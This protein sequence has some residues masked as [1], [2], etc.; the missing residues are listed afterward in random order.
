[1]PREWV[2]CTPI[3]AA[4][5]LIASLAGSLVHRDKGKRAKKPVGEHTLRQILWAATLL[6]KSLPLNTPM[7]RVN[8]ADMVALDRFFENL[9]INFGKAPKDRDLGVTLQLAI[10][11]AADEV[12][13]G[14]LEAGA[15]GLSIGTTNKH[16][17]KLAQIHKFMRVS[18][19]SA[20]AIDITKFTGTV[21]EN[22]NEAR[23]RLT[24]E[25]GEAIFRLP[26]WCGCVGTGDR[27]EPGPEIFHD[28][29]FYLLLLVWFTGAR[30]EELCKLMLNDIV[31][32]HDMPYLLI[33]PTETGGA[34]NRSVQAHDSGC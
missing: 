22:D 25:Q 30:R 27:L 11:E 23:D 33:R 24:R 29:L 8:E 17:G 16:F 20:P 10:A 14:L 26:P 34:K 6:E 13:S 19:L 4:A 2:D 12:E 5:R 3:Q 18:V 32:R 15:I 9:P 21:E 28:A 7:Y 31:S 1:M